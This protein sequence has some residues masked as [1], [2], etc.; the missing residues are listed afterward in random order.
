MFLS[1]PPGNHANTLACVF[2]VTWAWRAGESACLSW[3]F[4]GLRKHTLPVSLFFFP[5]LSH[6]HT[7][8]HFVSQQ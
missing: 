5:F 2:P 1:H 3:Y 8:M 6:A 4:L 7:E